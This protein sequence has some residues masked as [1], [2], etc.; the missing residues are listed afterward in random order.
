MKFSQ[1]CAFAALLAAGILLWN[2]RGILIELFGSVVLAVAL[3]TL[4]S[5]LERRLSLQRWQAL[6]LALALVVLVLSMIVALLIPPFIDQFSQLIEQVPRAASALIRLITGGL[7]RLSVMVHGQS[8][9]PQPD[10]WVQSITSRSDL[11]WSA[12]VARLLGLAGNLGG[13]LL[14]LIFVL[15][16]AVMLTAQPGG[17][18]GVAIQLMPS[19]LRR[20]LGDVL[21]R[22]GEALSSWMVGVLISSLCVG[23]L[24]FIGL[25]LLGVKLT[26]ANALI[27]G[28]SNVIPN[29]GPT[30]GTVFPMSVALLEN[31]W[32]PVLVLVLYVVIQNLESYVITPSVMHHQ[33]KLLP[34]LTLAAQVV[35]AVI[36]GPLGLLLALPLAVCLQVIV[37]ELLIHDLFDRWTGSTAP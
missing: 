17:Y 28:L 5:S 10:S 2:L 30:L 9:L 37:R 27:A 18:R 36:F 20:R 1:W 29:V 8:Q 25:S 33:L 15:A 23:V 12:G 13:A 4:V 19:I 7:G 21:D 24:A 26:L 3:S 14:H 22:C 11:P 16:V 32:K 6:L 35:F 31:P 34:G